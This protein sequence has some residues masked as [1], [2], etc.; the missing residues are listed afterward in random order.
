MMVDDEDDDGADLVALDCTFVGKVISP[1]VLHTNTISSTMNRP[2]EILGVYCF[3][4]R[5]TT[6]LWL[7]SALRWTG[8]VS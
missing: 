2:G 4:R 8:I 3:T 6:C 1:T 7:S 5:A